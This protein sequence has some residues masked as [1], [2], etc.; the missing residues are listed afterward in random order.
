M[1]TEDFTV[2]MNSPEKLVRSWIRGLMFISLQYHAANIELLGLKGYINCQ[3]QVP[4]L[5]T[6][7]LARVDFM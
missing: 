3:K 6:P 5:R 7:L 2:P 1:I 4:N